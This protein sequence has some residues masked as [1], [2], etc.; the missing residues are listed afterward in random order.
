MQRLFLSLLLLSA[1]LSAVFAQELP[2]A[3]DFFMDAMKIRLNK[4]PI[5]VMFSSVDCKF[6]EDVKREVLLDMNKMP[7]Y[8]GKIIIRNIDINSLKNLKD[9]NN[10]R[11]NHGNFAFRYGVRFVPV[12]ALMD[13]YGV[14]LKKIVGVRDLDFYWTDLDNAIDFA[15]KKLKN[16][17]NAKL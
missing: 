7:E 8:K 6:C 2:P 16:Q 5:L 9:F 13:D 12:V 14:I 3:K 11:T 1:S 17:L 4:T 10:D 15:T